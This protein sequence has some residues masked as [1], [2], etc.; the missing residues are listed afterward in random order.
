MNKLP[1]E[2]EIINAKLTALLR[3][4]TISNENVFSCR[5]NHNSSESERIHDDMN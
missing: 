4:G 3:A 1:S 2:L 5:N